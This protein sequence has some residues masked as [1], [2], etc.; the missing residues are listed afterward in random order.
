MRH[1]I[2][3][4]G[5]TLLIITLG[6]CAPDDESNLD[7]TTQNDQSSPILGGIVADHRS[8]NLHDIPASRIEEARSRFHVAYGHTSHGSQIVSGMNAIQ[9]HLGATYGWN[10]AGSGG[11]L[12]FRDT[13]FSGASDLGNPN[14]TAWAGATREYLRASSGVVDVVMWSWCGQVSDASVADINTYLDLMTGLE[15]EFP[16]VRFVYMTGHLDGS[17]AAGRLHQRNE[18][19]RRHCRSLNRILFDFADIESYDPDGFVD[20]MEKLADDECQ[21]DSDGNGSRDRNWANDWIAAHPS[22]ELTAIA[23]R[24]SSCQH[25]KSLNCVL[26]G[27]AFWWLLARLAGWP[28]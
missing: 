26:K 7:E 21:F 11:A 2:R 15:N 1:I 6:G 17:G 3:Y 22:H 13:P 5:P 23:R 8:T 27:A 14:R 9:S 18:Q 25:S 10:R 24:C 19:I 16:R 20:Y 28:G 4:V 12:G